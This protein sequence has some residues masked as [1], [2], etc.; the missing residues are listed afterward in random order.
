LIGQDDSDVELFAHLP[1]VA[2]SEDLNGWSLGGLPQIMLWT[3]TKNTNTSIYICIIY[4]YKYM[5]IYI[6]YYIYKLYI[7][8]SIC[9]YIKYMILYIYIISI[10]WTGMLKSFK[11]TS[12]KNHHY[13][14]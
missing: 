8:Y 6:L 4:I 9:I 7:L 11:S 5:C 3:L 14:Y 12:T 13:Y 2:Y 1:W 10:H